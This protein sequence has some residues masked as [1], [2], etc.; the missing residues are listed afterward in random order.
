MLVDKIG[1]H[2]TRQSGRHIGD[3]EYPYYH[4]ESFY[5]G[6]KRNALET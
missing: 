3:E 6:S 1:I 2:E 4:T 5:S